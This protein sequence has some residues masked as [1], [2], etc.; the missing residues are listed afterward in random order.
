M[1]LQFGENQ[2][3]VEKNLKGTDTGENHD[4]LGLGVE[5]TV[6]VVLVVDEDEGFGRGVAV[7]K[8]VWEKL[9]QGG[10]DCL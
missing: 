7:E 10:F 3:V 8:R 6:A 9:F 1:G 4:F 5:K 2:G